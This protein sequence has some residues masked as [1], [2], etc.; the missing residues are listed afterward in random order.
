MEELYSLYKEKFSGE[1]AI[2]RKLRSGYCL[3]VSTSASVFQFLN[4]PTFQE[5]PFVSFWR[6]YSNYTGKAEFTSPVR[7]DHGIVCDNH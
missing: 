4:I 6:V 1:H 5:P 7:K 3:Y 2:G